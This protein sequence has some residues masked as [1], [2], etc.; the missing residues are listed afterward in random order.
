M[1]EEVPGK[2]MIYC[3]DLDDT[4]CNTNGLDYSIS[5]PI[6]E[7]IYKVNQLFQAGHYIKIFTARGSETGIDWRPTTERQLEDWG[8]FHH[9]LILGKPA[10]DF[11]IDDKGHNVLTF[12]W[13]LA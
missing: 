4:L 8:V 13:S 10:A 9:E 7:R 5:T 3:F 1:A 12:D 11:Y 6:P 2:P